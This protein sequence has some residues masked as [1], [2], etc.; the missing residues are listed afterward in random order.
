MTKII[1]NNLTGINI[2]SNVNSTIF[3]KQIKSTTKID[4]KEIYGYFV[5]FIYT[6]EKKAIFLFINTKDNKIEY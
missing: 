1:K 2:N 3:N 4:Q 5:S 6:Y